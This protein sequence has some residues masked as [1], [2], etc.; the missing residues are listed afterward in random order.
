MSDS[1]MP[2]PPD[3]PPQPTPENKLTSE[4]FEAFKD[5][6]EVLYLKA[7][8]SGRIQFAKNWPAGAAYVL[9]E[10]LLKYDEDGLGEKA[11]KTELEE[12][13]EERRA[14]LLEAMETLEEKS[15]D[16]GALQTEYVRSAIEGWGRELSLLIYGAHLVDRMLGAA[17][18]APPVQELAQEA[19]AEPPAA[20]ESSAPVKVDV[21]PP[22]PA[23]PQ[24][25]VS[26]PKVEPSSDPMDA[27]K[28]IDMSSPPTEKPAPEQPTI[29]QEPAPQK[30]PAPP[31]PPAEPEPK[32]EPP[33]PPSETPP[34]PTAPQ[35]PEQ[36]PQ[37]PPQAPPQK[38]EDK[39][40]LQE[41]KSV[42][43]NV[44]MTFVSSKKKPAED[45]SDGGAGSSPP[46][47]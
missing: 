36:P 5:A 12:E 20:P 14:A 27:V 42:E 37:Q 32:V 40:S 11:R 2:P 23:Q 47:E 18:P 21:S 13:A 46:K 22:E 26:E 16:K 19:P 28:P 15:V 29:A 1:S 4:Q 10:E 9:G 31:Q 35:V 44:A 17:P 38:P 39:A 8:I 43:G 34:V 24:E 41:P 3:A 45:G 33:A 7:N 25:H 30:P 6:L